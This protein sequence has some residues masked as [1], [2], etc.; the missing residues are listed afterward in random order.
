M[1]A[2]LVTIGRFK[3][4]A[5]GALFAQYNA[6]LRPPLELTEIPEANGS[7]AEARRR[8]GA[9]ILAA[10]PANALLV[11]LD[12]G[13]TAPSS[14]ALAQLTER[15]EAAARPLCFA[16]GGAEGLDPAVTQRAEHRL[17]LG[18]LTWPHLLVRALLAEQLFRAQ[19]IRANHPYHRAW[20]P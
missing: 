9:A 12:L 7:P 17:S 8:E 15:W 14:E 20:R 4:G 18:P 3:S 5:E 6:R 1:K 16:I 2:R 11:A 10:L 19:C 13:A